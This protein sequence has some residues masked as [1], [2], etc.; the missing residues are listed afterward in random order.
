[1]PRT[2]KLT[3]GQIRDIAKWR[4]LGRTYKQIGKL[5]GCTPVQARHWAIAAGQA[6]A[7]FAGRTLADEIAA[8][9][10]E[11]RTAPPFKPGELAW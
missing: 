8:A 11:A 4:A 10:I 1:M 5:V 3:P 9:R 6:R 2:T 7:R